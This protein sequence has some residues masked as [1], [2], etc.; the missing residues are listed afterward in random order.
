M[1][2]KKAKKYLLI[3]LITVLLLKL[4]FYL[5]PDAIGVA[6]ILI[7]IGNVS[8]IMGISHSMSK[9]SKSDEDSDKKE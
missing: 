7:I 6:A 3:S 9:F 4:S 5:I 1:N 8:I 2:N